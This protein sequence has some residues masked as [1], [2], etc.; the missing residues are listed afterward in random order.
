M[1]HRMRLIMLCASTLVF[2]GL[3]GC[4]D[5]DADDPPA[6]GGGDTS[7]AGGNDTSNTGDTGTGLGVDPCNSVV[8][9]GGDVAGTWNVTGSCIKVS[10]ELDMGAFGLVE[11]CDGTVTGEL[12][13]TGTWTANGDG[14]Y[15]DATTTTG[16]ETME[17]NAACKSLSGTVTTCD[18]MSGP[19]KAYGYNELGCVDN[20]TTGGCTCTATIDQTAVLGVI[21]GYGSETGEYTVTGTTLET[22]DSQYSYCVS[23]TTLTVTP[24]AQPATGALAGSIILQR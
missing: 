19:I 10:G 21:P 18:R 7:T 13:V 1:N 5:Y 6:V 22:S 2:A 17:L 23:G 14:T 4:G 24:L 3:A 15:T 9:C 11:A 16:T 12:T 20:P 8:P